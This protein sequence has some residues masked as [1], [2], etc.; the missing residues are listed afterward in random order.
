MKLHHLAP[1]LGAFALAAVG[2]ASP[3][4][5]AAGG[6]RMLQT[7][8]CDGQD[9]TIAVSSG[10][11]GDNWGAARLVDGG[12]LIPVSLEY[13][14]FDDT[15]DLVLDDETVQHGGPA[16]SRQQTITCVVS[17]QGVLGDSAPPDFVLP[18]GAALT[19]TITFSLLVTAV[20][21]P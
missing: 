2:A 14:V 15:A 19:D 1:V 3:A 12:T 6:G 21:R 9:V 8:S 4:Q 18:D 7:F 10:N 16:H 17:E 13:L 11:D 20:P 5:A